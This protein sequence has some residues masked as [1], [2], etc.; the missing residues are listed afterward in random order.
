M[1][2]LP[3]SDRAMKTVYRQGW[4]QV[5]EGS[6]RSS[7]TFISSLAWLYYIS[8]VSDRY[9]LMTGKTIGSLIR[10]V[11]ENEA[12]IASLVPT[13]RKTDAIGTYY[14]IPTP[15]G[16][17]R[18]YCFGGGDSDSHK[19]LVGLTVAGWYAD[20]VSEHHP[21]FIQECFNRTIVSSTDRRHFW[22][23]NPQA[24][25]HII[26]TEYLDRFDELTKAENDKAGGYRWYHFTLKDNPAL[27][28]ET[29]E[30]IAMQYT[31]YAYERYIL[32]R[33]VI[34]EGLIFPNIGAEHFK[35]FDR[36]KV[37]CRF[38]AMDFG[39]THATAWYIGGPMR[40]EH[41]KPIRDD[42]R[43][44][45]EYYDQ[46]SGK[47][48]TDYADDFIKMCEDIGQD[49]RRMSVAVDPAANVLR[50][51]LLK[52]GIPCY[53][54]ENAVLDGIH[55]VD[56]LTRK[57]RLTYHSSCIQARNG[58]ATY[59]WDPKASERGEDKPIKADDDAMDA[60]RYLAL[61]HMRH[62]LLS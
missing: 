40:D 38:V 12:G 18:C 11:F 42:W 33:R 46:G 37:D 62:L 45:Y 44:C 41:G 25:R 57:G 43:V 5:W 10:N 52:K 4:L 17:K 1:K 28:P 48:T 21:R 61:T 58:F 31:G 23:L 27:T 35:D 30:A 20:E 6:V 26:Y 3:P 55:A 9:F 50:L 2:L 54:A 8:T 13:E 15:K 36:S 22:T 32:G 14:D 56:T 59:S 19:S 39:S 47:D 49:P 51:S 60:I 29:I 34:A 53:N 16:V 24:P 7:K